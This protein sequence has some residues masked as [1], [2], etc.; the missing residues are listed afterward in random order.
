[1]KEI[2]V[3]GK[4]IE[5]A[6]S[7]AL[8]E[9]KATSEEVEIKVLNEG[10]A[11]LFGLM[12]AVPARVRA[13]LKAAE[14]ADFPTTEK[15]D[16]VFRTGEVINSILAR[17]KIEA[18]SSVQLEE[19]NKIAA[20]I[21]SAESGLLIG[22]KGQTLDAFQFILNLII[23]KEIKEGKIPKAKFEDKYKVVIDTERYRLRRQESLIKQAKEAAERVSQ[24]GQKEELKPMSSHDRQIV[25]LA[26]KEMSAVKTISEGE[27][28]FRRVI[29]LPAK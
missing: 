28:S 9:L 5:E 13:V 11:G 23:S 4:T 17:M 8:S 15:M 22:R 24:T 18:K 7:K 27:G 1:M 26:L 12:G 10:K 19:N 6:I 21:E 20:N 29:I 25:H 16:I 2:E 3:E 14:R